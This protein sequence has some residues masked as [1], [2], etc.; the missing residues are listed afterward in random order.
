MNRQEYMEAA[1]AEVIAAAELP[2][3]VTSAHRRYY[4]Q[5]VDDEVKRVVL[6]CIGIER[7]KE[8]ADSHFNDI[9]IRNWDRMVLLPYLMRGDDGKTF[10]PGGYMSKAMTLAEGSAVSASLAECVCIY[11]EA[12]RQLVE[13]AATV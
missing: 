4:G 10:S 9:P 8:S 2:E 3:D 5:F 13:E 1:A 6:L 12:A 7:L 11:K